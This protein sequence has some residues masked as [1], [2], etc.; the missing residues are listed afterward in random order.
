MIK[1]LQEVFNRGK[2]V[3]KTVKGFRT[4]TLGTPLARSFV[5]S[6][7]LSSSRVVLGTSEDKLERS[8]PA[9]PQ[10]TRESSGQRVQELPVQLREDKSVLQRVRQRGLLDDM[11]RAKRE[12]KRDIIQ[13]REDKILEPRVLEQYQVEAHELIKLNIIREKKRNVDKFTSLQSYTA[14]MQAYDQAFK[15][16]K[17]KES[18]DDVD[19]LI[20]NLK[21]ANEHFNEKAKVLS[22]LAD[23]IA[24]VEVKLENSRKEMVQGLIFS[25]QL[26]NRDKQ[27]E[28]DVINKQKS[29]DGSLS[30]LAQYHSSLNIINTSIHRGLTEELL[31]WVDS[32]IGQYGTNKL[33]PGLLNDNS[34]S[35]DV[36]RTKSTQELL[37]GMELLIHRLI[38]YGIHV[39]RCGGYRAIT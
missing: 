34:C 25:A 7:N 21:L 1:S 16:I 35:Q 10:K 15:Q 36:I 8:M 31:F 14:R 3:N 39:V 23:E 30:K 29:N 33:L 6:H 12:A 24:S 27:A 18:S 28:T 13:N 4:T 20:R 26:N 22:E 17:N 37:G 38:T 5:G 2:L 19:N 9:S 32:V 11:I